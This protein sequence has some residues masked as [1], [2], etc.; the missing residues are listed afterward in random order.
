MCKKRIILFFLCSL[1]FLTS[2]VTGAG[3]WSFLNDP[4]L[5]TDINK[6]GSLIQA[7]NLG[8]NAL[9]VRVGG[10]TY[11]SNPDNVSGGTAVGSLGYYSGSDTNIENLLNTGQANESWEWPRHVQFDFSDLVIDADYRFQVFVAFAGEGDGDFYIGDWSEYEWYPSTNMV[12]VTYEWTADA[13]TI[14]IRVGA[15]GDDNWTHMD[16]MAFTLH[17]KDG[18]QNI[19]PPNGA[20][21]V[22]RITVLRS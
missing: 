14:S 5:E 6:S 7:G 22:P 1:L 15:N 12:L 10:I 21:E 4:D 2:N 9:T 8:L 16:T 3:T 18:I 11:L 20:T 13:D 17:T 19:H